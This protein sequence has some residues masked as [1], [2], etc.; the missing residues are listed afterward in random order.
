MQLKERF[1]FMTLVVL[2]FLPASG[3]AAPII[4]LGGETYSAGSL[5]PDPDPFCTI[6]CGYPSVSRGKVAQK[7]NCDPGV[8]APTGN[9][10]FRWDVPA[11]TDQIGNQI[12]CSGMCNVPT[13][14]GDVVY[15]AFRM[16]FQNPNGD[17]WHDGPGANSADK[18]LGLHSPG[19]S[20]GY[21]W[22]LSMGC[23]DSATQCL[24]HHFT[25]WIGNPSYHFN[26]GGACGEVNDIYH[27]N[28]SP[29][30]G[31]TV[32]Q[33]SYNRW[34]NIVMGIKMSSGSNGRAEA[35]V[36][37]QKFLDCANI[38]TMNTSNNRFAY[39]EFGGTIAQPAYDA[40]A[41]TRFFDDIT[42]TKSWSEVSSFLVDP[43]SGASSTLP[44]A[45]SNLRVQ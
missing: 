33:L 7:S 25:L 43:E 8:S 40:P 39:I 29:Y 44:P 10:C 13:S 19:L 27:P 30:V 1:T 31:G 3:Q 16:N 41:H 22:D 12:Q 35:W 2:F 20:G 5:V 36:N 24:D 28:V 21:R 18:G 9:N 32:P 6:S 11:S 4:N 38:K 42:V 45:P 17:I 34:H 15:L 14:E 26:V 37:G 23:W